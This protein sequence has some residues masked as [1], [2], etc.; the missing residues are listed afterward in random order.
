MKIS[1]VL[2]ANVKFS[3]VA[4]HVTVKIWCVDTVSAH[5]S[6]SQ[7]H[8]PCEILCKSG[9]ETIFGG[10]FCMLPLPLYSSGNFLLINIA[11]Q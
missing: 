11:H 10:D 4:C 1:V 5:D 6:T 3:A 7:K 8:P 9:P 2:T